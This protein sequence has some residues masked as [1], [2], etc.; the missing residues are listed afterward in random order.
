MEKHPKLCFRSRWEQP[1][2]KGGAKH[3]FKI[4]IWAGISKR[5]ATRILIFSRNMNATLYVNEILEKNSS[6]L[7]PKHTRRLALTRP[8]DSER[9]QLVQDTSDSVC[10]KR[11]S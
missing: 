2:L 4:H 8:H 7:H 5:G 1:K 9:N 11:D 3:P 10:G 6:A